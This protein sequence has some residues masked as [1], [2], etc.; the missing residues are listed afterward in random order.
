V[1]GISALAAP[2]LTGSGIVLG[3]TAIG[4]SASFDVGLDGQAAQR[5]ARCAAELSAQLGARRTTVFA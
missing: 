5:L 1:P 3:L 2:V 4:P